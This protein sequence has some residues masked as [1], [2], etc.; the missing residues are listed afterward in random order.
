MDGSL[1]GAIRIELQ[2][3][4]CIL[5]RCC[6]FNIR[7]WP[8]SYLDLVLMALILTY[9]PTHHSDLILHSSFVR[10]CHWLRE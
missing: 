10:A 6:G 1:I 7:F 3:L 8:L 4:H 2:D 5:V 9:E